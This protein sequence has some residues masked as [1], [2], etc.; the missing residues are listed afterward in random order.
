MLAGAFCRREKLETLETGFETKFFHSAA[1]AQA[2]G[3]V[4]RHPAKCRDARRTWL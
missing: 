3:I 4:R 1:T 2:S